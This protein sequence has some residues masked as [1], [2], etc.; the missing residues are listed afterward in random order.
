MIFS[1]T[2]GGLGNQL[3]Q[4][5]ATLH[6]CLENGYSYVFYNDIVVVPNSKRTV[7]W[8][9]ILYALKPHLYLKPDLMSLPFYNIYIQN[10]K[11][12]TYNKFPVVDHPNHLFCYVYSY[13]QSEK[14][15]K[16]RFSEIVDLLKLN[17]QRKRVR[18]LYPPNSISI[19]FRIGDYKD[20]LNENK[21]VILPLL[22]YK[23]A[24]RHLI[25]QH[26]NSSDN[27]YRNVVYF[28]EKEDQE[29]IDTMISELQ[30]EF[31]MLHFIPISSHLE[32][33][34]QLLV[35]SNCHHHIIANS[36]FSWWGAYLAD[37]PTKI[38][39]Y[40]D[41]WFGRELAD[42][43]TRDLIPDTW[44]KCSCSNTTP[45]PA[46]YYFSIGCVFK[47]EAHILYEFLEY[48]FSHGVDH[49]Y[50][51]NDFSED[52]YLSIL[53]PYLQ[54]GRVTLFQ[55]DVVMSD[56]NRQIII[57]NK[58]FTGP[59]GILKETVWIG[60]LDMDEFLYSPS[61][62]HL[63]HVLKTWEEKTDCIRVEWVSFGSNQH[64]LQP[65]SVLSAFDTCCDIHSEVNKKHYSYKSI[66]KSEFVEELGIHSSKLSSDRCVNLSYTNNGPCELLI[67]H[68]RIQSFDFFMRVKAKRGDVNNYYQHEGKRRDAEEF[69]M[70][71]KDC[72]MVVDRRLIEQ[73]MDLIRKVKSY[74][75]SRLVDRDVTVVITSC[76]RAKLLKL[77]L[78]SF[79]KYNTYPIKEFI[80][81]DDSGVI[82]VNDFLVQDPAY[83]GLP[84]RLIYNKENIGQIK[85]IDKAYE[86][87]TTSYIFHCEEDWEFLRSG[88]IERSFSILDKDPHIFTV[89]LRPHHDLSDHPIDYGSYNSELG[90]YL[91]SRSYTYWHSGFNIQ[92]TWCGVTLNPGLRRTS[93][94][95]LVHPFSVNIPSDKCSYGIVGEYDINVTYGELGFCAAITDMVDGY[96]NHIGWGQHVS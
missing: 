25:N 33:W 57:Y 75:I 28:F 48:Y 8:D 14:Y 18:D 38:I 15:F 92:H 78:D 88:F 4:V 69:V 32:D 91:M 63:P 81:I 3:F 85:S 60:I 77:T 89:W 7:Y 11:L 52:D 34:E 66:M 93:D 27:A 65:F 36:S 79:L 21:Y 94:A 68:Y 86:Y 23:N 2:A 9:N 87:V 26:G 67:H 31:P 72:N 70:I 83:A 22:Y 50:M 64:V 47:N 10:E 46:K 84:I 43:D 49:I 39:C 62:L 42:L 37:H 95:M 53:D 90:F 19:H 41:Q 55:N 96:V 17:E 13:C 12:F 59:Q 54:E 1:H 76:N 40:P 44:I 24:L 30:I 45:N 80:V 58:Y 74:K 35:M 56:R 16:D 20:D 73:N 61:E 51:I 82:G 71:D 5:F 29:R 6:H